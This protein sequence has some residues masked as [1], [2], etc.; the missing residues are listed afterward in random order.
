[1]IRSPGAAARGR[2][3]RTP[4]RGPVRPR[5]PPL[6]GLVAALVPAVAR[7]DCPAPYPLSSLAADL[8]AMQTSLRSLDEAAFKAA[9]ERV[10]AGLSCMAQPAP[11]AVYASTYRLLGAWHHLGGDAAE[12][13]RWFRTAVELDPAFDWDVQDFEVRHPI[14]ILY[15]EQSDDPRNP[16]PVAGRS[17]RVPPGTRLLLDGR[18]LAEAAATPNRPHLVQQVGD[19]RA[20]RASWLISG[21]AFPDLLLGAPTGGERPRVAPRE[22]T[23]VPPAPKATGARTTEEGIVIVQRARPP[24][25]TPLLVAGGAGL[26]GAGALYATSLAARRRFDE[27]ATTGEVTAARARTNAL[28][29]ASAGTAALGV[30]FGWWGIL[31]D[32]G[33]GLGLAGRF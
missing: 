33:F 12:A 24:L 14:R 19:D 15:G 7:A 21:N 1:M 6:L 4:T 13:A 28:V 22:G 2:L 11:P 3:E 16:V 29:I 10:S 9:G 17:L 25:K 23:G 18:P 27:A 8:G 26:A 20:V 30:G 32:D 5:L 31:L